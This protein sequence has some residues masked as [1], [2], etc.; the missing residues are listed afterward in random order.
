MNNDAVNVLSLG[1]T[2]DWSPEL[3]R[4]NTSIDNVHEECISISAESDEQ[5]KVDE[6][7]LYERL[8]VYYQS[9]FFAYE[10]EE[11]FKQ[12]A[13]ELDVKI[14]PKANLALK[15][16]QMYA[17]TENS[18]RN[19]NWAK[20]LN[21][22]RHKEV[23]LADVVQFLT[24]KGGV[25][26]CMREVK[27]L[28]GKVTKTKAKNEPNEWLADIIIEETSLEAIIVSPEHGILRGPLIWAIRTEPNGDTE[29]VAGVGP[30]E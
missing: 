3:D 22:M 7:T 5:M 15:I 26:G 29:F 28:K 2:P 4:L 10:D 18:T 21:Y 9:V 13:T 14:T 25:V 19:G 6:V 8:S 24:K 30:K 11:R 1:E 23:E 17:G 20:A 27:K 16:V 12:L